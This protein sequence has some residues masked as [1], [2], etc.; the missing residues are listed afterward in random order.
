MKELATL[1]LS[2]VN[3]SALI[4]TLQQLRDEELEHLD[5][6]VEEMS[7]RA[8]AHALLSYVV[9]ESCKFVIEVCKTY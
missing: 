1:N 7:Q 8:P 3:T 5:I 6:A 4:S 9:G 2:Y